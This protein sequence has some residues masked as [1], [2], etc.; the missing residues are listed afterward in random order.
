MVLDNFP[1]LLLVDGS[2][3][4]RITNMGIL[5]TNLLS[6]YPKECIFQISTSGIN[7]N[8]SANS[9]IKYIVDKRSILFG[10]YGKIVEYN[11][12]SNSRTKQK[13][14]GNSLVSN[15]KT[16]FPV[17][18]DDL[19]QLIRLRNTVYHKKLLSLIK[20][21]NP[22]Y[23]LT[24]GVTISELYIA[25]HLSKIFNL[26]IIIYISDDYIE[27]NHS[28]FSIFS[29]FLKNKLKITFNEIMKRSALRFVVSELMKIEYERRY[30]IEFNV[31]MDGIDTRYYKET[32]QPLLS[33]EFTFTFLGSLEPNRWMNLSLLGDALDII[34]K[35]SKYKCIFHIYAFDSERK[36]YST[37]LSAQSIELKDEISFED[38]PIVQIKSD[39]LVH[40]ECFPPFVHVNQTKYSMSTKI[41]QYLASGT[42]IL[43]FGPCEVASIK[44]LQDYEATTIITTNELSSIILSIT[45]LLSNIE[46]KNQQAQ[47]HK[48]KVILNCSIENVSRNFNES[49]CSYGIK[50]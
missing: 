18:F 13:S 12:I 25:M 7:D 49:V 1:R 10:S 37:R 45:K 8:S 22:N 31:L 32:V 28:K 19:S 20:E 17:F 38:V 46:L 50:E 14:Q 24:F 35:E 6:N 44:F 30:G 36:I 40:V 33:N 9:M 42:P 41:M 34:N 47:C 4:S 2:P 48:K 3:L 21:F 11:E 23:I 29:K 16:R 26:P 27:Y 15:L 39:I 5:K 43:A